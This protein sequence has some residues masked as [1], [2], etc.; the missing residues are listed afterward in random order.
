M[1]TRLRATQARLL[2]LL[3]EERPVVTLTEFLLAR[4]AEDEVAAREPQ[5]L[6]LEYGV[7]SAGR[8]A[9]SSRVL[10]ECEAK[11][12]IVE[13]LSPAVDYDRDRF[14]VQS[15]LE[16]AATASLRFLALP[17]ADHPDYREEWK[18]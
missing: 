17:Y 6:A 9:F 15:T 2:Y 5:W 10:A 8:A 12:R 11:R 4:I 18:P 3:R 13:E 7:D 1:R 14:I 16:A